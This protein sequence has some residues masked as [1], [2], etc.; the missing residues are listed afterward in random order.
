MN[1]EG[2][3]GITGY[4]A[5]VLRS[6][7]IIFP[8]DPDPSLWSGLGVGQ[9]IKT[10]DMKN[11]IITVGIA[12]LTSAGVNAQDQPGTSTTD[13]AGIL[14]NTEMLNVELDL[15]DQQKE[16][17]RDINERFEKKHAEMM[18][19]VPKPTDAQVSEKV[20]GLMKERDT[21]LRGVLNADQYAKWEKKRH[22]GTSELQEKERSKLKK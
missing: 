21:A 12:L 18:A 7:G 14:M 22:K 20:E 2:N 1:P 16:D 10:K 4:A 3:G 8:V 13:K 5:Y 6:S 9:G 15:N 11:M 19:H 17:V